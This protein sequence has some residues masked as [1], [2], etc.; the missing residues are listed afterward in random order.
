MANKADINWWSKLERDWKEELVRN[1]L[2]SPKY[3][4]RNLVLTDIYELLDESAEIITEIV[5]IEKLHIS[6]HKI[7]DP[8]PLFHLKKIEDFLIQLPHWDDNK[9]SFL[10]WYP[11][12]LRSKVRRLDLD[13]IIFNNDLSPL[14]EFINLEI[15]NCR[16]CQIESL[17]GIQNLTKLKIFKSDQGNSYSDLNPLRG[18]NLVSLNIQSTKVT[19]ISPLIDLPSLEWIDLGFLSISALSPLL[20]MPNLKSVV[21]PANVEIQKDKLEE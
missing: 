9:A 14:S 21:V 8:A 10:N 11:E 5:N 19:D 12:H 15:L 18:L 4:N 13:G 16:Y 17:E 3:R 1:L 6:W 20:K 7:N 2:D